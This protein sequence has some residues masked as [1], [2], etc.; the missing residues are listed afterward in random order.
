MA[1]S[2]EEAREVAAKIG[3]PVMVR[4]SYVLGGRAMRSCYDDDELREY[5]KLAT[6]ASE[7]HPVLI[8][9]F[10]EDAIEV[11]VDVLAD[12]VKVV[13]GGVL[14]HI[15]EAGV[16]SGDA[17][18]A[19]PPYTLP[20]YLVDRMRRDAVRLAL[21]LR[22]KGLMN[23]QYAVKEDQVYV[24][25]VNP[26]ASRTVPF[27]AKATGRPLAKIA[28]RIMVGKSLAD[29]GIDRELPPP[30]FTVKKSVFPWNRFPGMR[31]A[32]RPR[33]ALDGRG[34]GSRPRLRRRV[35]QGSVGRQ[36]GITSQGQGLLVGA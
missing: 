32:P 23:V 18:C 35:R 21:A 14:E 11:D 31:S 20:P 8:D 4:P 15:E 34:H 5:V 17:S 28:A 1:R 16:H 7:D 12:G 10:L 25:E 3:F 36:R 9:E 22:V 33:D 24:L 29:L 13:V 6:E 27:V 19:F 2:F 26:R 30:R